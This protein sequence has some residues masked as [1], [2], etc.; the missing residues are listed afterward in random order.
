MTLRVPSRR[1][2][3]LAAAGTL[4]LGMAA[5]GPA[6]VASAVAPF[7]FSTTSLSTVTVPAGY[8]AIDWTLIGGHGGT[9]PAS[10]PG[11]AG[12]EL[13][14]TTPV[15]AGEQYELAAGSAGTAYSGGGAGG[16]NLTS[17]AYNGRGGGGVAGGGGAASTRSTGRSTA[18]PTTP[19]RQPH[20]GRPGRGHRRAL[21]RPG[22]TDRSDRRRR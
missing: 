14:V 4:G 12:G 13:R 11:L 8:C 22:R 10:V 3:G 15:T 5:F 20:R 6:G 17:S 18:P 19:G 1:A 9:N 16:T 7:T 2:L 21:R